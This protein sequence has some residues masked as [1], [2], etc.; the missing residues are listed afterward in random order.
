MAVL[1]NVDF[2]VL[3]HW[4]TTAQVPMPDIGLS[5]IIPTLS[6]SIPLPYAGNT[7]TRQGAGKYQYFDSAEDV[8][9]GVRNGCSTLIHSVRL[10]SALVHGTRTF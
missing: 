1:T 2:I 10:Y 8:S 9:E 6:Q 5:H 3:P 7:N 4:D